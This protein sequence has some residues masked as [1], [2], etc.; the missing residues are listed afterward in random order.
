MV[1][2]LAQ[3]CWPCRKFYK[4]CVTTPL[5]PEFFDIAQLIL[6]HLPPSA[7]LPNVYACDEH[8]RRWSMALERQG[9]ITL[10]EQ[11]VIDGVLASDLSYTVEAL[12]RLRPNGRAIF[13]LP[14]TADVAS[15]AVIRTL[16]S[17]G[18]VRI[19]TEAVLDDAYLLARGE[20]PTE[21]PRPIERMATI[22]GESSS[23]VE[24]IE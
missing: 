7:D 19:L 10:N 2:I 20:R 14:N 5:M 3:V 12:Q 1:H 9:H 24:A 21:Q 6:K 22:A 18:F 13:L 15:E 4:L 17:T 23:R 11:H 16:T 8:S